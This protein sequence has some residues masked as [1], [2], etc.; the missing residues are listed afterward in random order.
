MM[1]FYFKTQPP[2]TCIG[3][4]VDHLLHEVD[5]PAS[6][7]SWAKVIEEQAFV[8]HDLSPFDQ[9]ESFQE[10]A[11]IIMPGTWDISNMAVLELLYQSSDRQTS[12]NADG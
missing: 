5:S 2:I 4:L 10:Y 1:F 7:F 6:P 8:V 11:N 3:G 9:A 12:L